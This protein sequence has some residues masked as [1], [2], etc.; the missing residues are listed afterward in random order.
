MQLHQ[1]T[2]ES[3][4]QTQRETL[5]NALWRARERMDRARSDGEYEACRQ[6]EIAARADL[7]QY[8]WKHPRRA[9]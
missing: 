4:M 6:L 3:M 2:M 1:T 8:D 9:A 7:E 5:E